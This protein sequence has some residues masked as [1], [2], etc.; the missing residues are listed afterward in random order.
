[1]YLCVLSRHSHDNGDRGTVGCI[2]SGSGVC[3]GV[4][5][6]FAAIT[7]SLPS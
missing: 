7:A 3:A 5:M 4:N 1:M 2:T 6:M